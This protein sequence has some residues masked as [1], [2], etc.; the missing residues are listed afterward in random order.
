MKDNLSSIVFVLNGVGPVLV[1]FNEFTLTPASHV[2]A[3]RLLQMLH[4]RPERMLERIQFLE[5]RVSEYL[6]LDSDETI[7]WYWLL[8][9]STE[10]C[11]RCIS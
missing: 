1:N 10:F 8:T 2:Q 4:Q 6:E 7:D 9:T 5:D 3:D 11:P